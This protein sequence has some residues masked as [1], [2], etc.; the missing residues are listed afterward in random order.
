MCCRRLFRHST[1]YNDFFF[2]ILIPLSHLGSS[3]LG[4]R[5]SLL[6]RYGSAYRVQRHCFLRKIRRRIPCGRHRQHT[7]A[8]LPRAATSPT[9]KCPSTAW[10]RGEGDFRSRHVVL[11][12]ISRAVD[13]RGTTR[14]G[15]TSQ[16]RNG[17][18]VGLRRC[19]DT[20]LIHIRRIA[21]KIIG[22]HPVAVIRIG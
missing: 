13:P 7:S 5:K 19:D 17:K 21:G 10:L 1:P 20:H 4:C 18:S 16:E 15:S 6:Q 3:R 2:P 22:M 9:R 12:T 8:A 11:V 14:Q